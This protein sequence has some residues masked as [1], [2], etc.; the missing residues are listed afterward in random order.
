MSAVIEKLRRSAQSEREL[1]NV[2]AAANFESKIAELERKHCGLV[3]VVQKLDTRAAVEAAWSAMDQTAL[4]DV[5]C[6]VPGLDRKVRK[7]M[8]MSEAIR[9]LKNGAW[10]VGRTADLVQVQATT[11]NTSPLVPDAANKHQ[12]YI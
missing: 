4:V 1:G 6:V 2:A 8:P 5:L 10:L 9:E 11:S 12:L 3:P 7:T